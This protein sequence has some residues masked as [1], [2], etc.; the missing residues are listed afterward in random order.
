MH[1]GHLLSTG[2]GSC[3]ESSALVLASLHLHSSRTA[4]LYSRQ[5]SAQTYKQQTR[6]TKNKALNSTKALKDH[7]KGEAQSYDCKSAR[8]AKNNL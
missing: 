1:Q 5:A 4:F 8:N 6:T 3:S 2:S 7:T